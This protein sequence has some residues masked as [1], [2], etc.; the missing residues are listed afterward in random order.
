M[1]KRGGL[2]AVASELISRN[3]GQESTNV[4]GS[5]AITTRRF[6]VIASSAS[7]GAFRREGCAGVGRDSVEHF[8]RCLAV[9]GRVRD[10]GVVLVDVERDEPFD[11]GERVETSGVQEVVFHRAPEGFDHGVGVGD[12]TLRDALLHA[13]VGE[14][15]VDRFAVVFAAT[16]GEQHS[17]RMTGDGSAELLNEVRVRMRFGKSAEPSLVSSLRKPT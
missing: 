12:V 1:R 4:R 9:E 2:I 3:Y 11:G 6:L 10:R 5:V 7:V 8:L 16:V 17:S 15:S 13:G 14:R